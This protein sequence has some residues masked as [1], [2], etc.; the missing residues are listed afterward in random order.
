MFSPT[1][2]RRFV[3]GPSGGTQKTPK[4]ARVEFICMDVIKLAATVGPLLGTVVGAWLQA[5]YG[6]VRLKVGSE[7]I[8]VEGRTTRQLRAVL[9]LANE[10]QRKQRTVIHEP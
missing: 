10:Y 7:G 6:R 8:E 2:V 1:G 3:G 5:H 9:D 4:G